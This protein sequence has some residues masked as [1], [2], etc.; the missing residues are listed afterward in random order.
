MPKEEK[1]KQVKVHID[2]KSYEFLRDTEV[3]GAE[4]KAKAGIGSDYELYRKVPGSATDELITDTK[5]L[6]LEPGMH[7]FSALKSVTPG[8]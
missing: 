1:E 5:A 4:L 3:T 8:N 6:L 2:N 7:F